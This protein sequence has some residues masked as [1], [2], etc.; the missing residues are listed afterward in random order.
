MSSPYFAGNKPGTK[1]LLGPSGFATIKTKSPTRTVKVRAHTRTV[2]VK[3]APTLAQTVGGAATELTSAAKTVAQQPPKTITKAVSVS[4]RTPAAVNTPSVRPAPARVSTVQRFAPHYR[5]E[6]VAGYVTRP[7]V[8]AIPFYT[9]AYTTQHRHGPAGQ[10]STQWNAADVAQAHRIQV[11]NYGKPGYILRSLLPGGLDEGGVQ[12]P[13]KALSRG[14]AVASMLPGGGIGEAAGILGFGLKGLRVTRAAKDV[15]A[16]APAAAHVTEEAAVVRGALPGAKTVRG[17]QEAGYSPARAEK[18]AAASRYKDDTSLPPAERI[19]KAKNELRGELPKINFQGFSELNDEAVQALQTHILNHP[20]L[21]FFQ[22]LRLSEAL[23]NALAGK[24]P[25]RS[26]ITLFEHVFGKDT[27][28]G[29]DSFAKNP[30]RDRLLS[31]L[32]IPRSLMASFDL[33]A[34]FRQGLMV[35]TR[36][37]TIFARNFGSMIKAFGSESVY[38]GMI[39]EIRARPTYPLMVEAKLPLTE[40]GA[41]VGAREERFASD[42]AEKLTGGKYGPVRASG[43]AYTGFLDKTRA[44]VFDHL[45]QRAQAQGINVQDEKFLRSLGKYIGS[46]TG[47]GDLGEFQEAGKVLNAV[48]FSPRLLASR[49]NFLSPRY[50]NKLDPFARKEALRSAVQLAGT[51]SAL[52]ALASRM[53]GV[54]VETDPRNP[55]WGKIKL[56]NTRIDIG[57][58][59]QQPLRLLAQLATGVAISSTTGKSLSL[60]TGGYGKPTRLDIVQ[61]F[62]MGKESPIASLVTDWARGSTLI[63]QKFSWPQELV[64]RMTPLLAQDSYELYKEKH[65]GMNGLAAAFAGYGVG[66]LGFGMQTYGPTVPKTRVPAPADYFGGSGSGGGSPY[67]SSPSQSGGGGYFGP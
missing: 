19:A 67:F 32:N 8:A 17:K 45:I 4:D 59:F 35:S 63:G 10:E 34:P 2:K 20:H 36:H 15:A 22:R 57:G 12:S 47:R 16:A 7:G 13:G 14:V 26:E 65:G 27:A 50:Y 46:A 39:D 66:S 1:S 61:R 24:V 5:G 30:F 23:T 6:P 49:L 54:K 53:P 21:L 48:L 9:D 33:S 62:F 28:A 52:V 44:D 51:A 42:Y 38:H 11:A 60:T 64:Q 43:R 58:G 55:D 3:P 56:G 37:P 29:L 41:D 18:V 25:T 31:V 40:L